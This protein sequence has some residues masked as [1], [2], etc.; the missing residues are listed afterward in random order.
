MDQRHDFG[1]EEYLLEPGNSLMG[2]EKSE[3]DAIIKLIK[4]VPTRG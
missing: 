4:H 2:L 3:N 1:V